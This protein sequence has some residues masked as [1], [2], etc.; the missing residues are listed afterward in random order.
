MSPRRPRCF[1][2]KP[3]WSRR[4]CILTRCAW[5]QAP[6]SAAGVACF[7]GLRGA[8]PPCCPRLDK[9]CPPGA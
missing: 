4:G 9:R 8:F 3:G 5:C 6:P 1:F 2:S 7:Q